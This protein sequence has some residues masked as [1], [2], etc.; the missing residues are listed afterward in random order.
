MDFLSENDSYL[1]NTKEV[2]GDKEF[3]W[4][5]DKTQSKWNVPSSII[6]CQLAMRD[7]FNDYYSLKRISKVNTH[8][9]KLENIAKQYINELFKVINTK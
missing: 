3:M 9:F 2:L 8:R 5:Y 7:C 1:V 6:E 4:L